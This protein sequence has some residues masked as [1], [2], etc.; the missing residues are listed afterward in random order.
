MKLICDRNKKQHYHDVESGR[1]FFSVSQIR[2][3]L[4]DSY[5]GAPEVFLE[6]ARQRGTSLHLYLALLLYARAG[7]RKMPNPWPGLEGYC[8]AIA[9]WAER[10]QVIPLKVETPSVCVAHGFAG[11]PDCLASYGSKQVTAIIDLKTG[12]TETPTDGIQLHLYKMMDGYTDA[13]LLIDL[14][15]KDDG[16]YKEVERKPDPIGV[17]AA[18]NAISILRWRASL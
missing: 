8:D 6:P 15:V 16:T 5:A 10:N 13:R 18:M 12:S 17:A 1:D 9:T 7:I 3:V 2:K 4:H 11:T 14:Y